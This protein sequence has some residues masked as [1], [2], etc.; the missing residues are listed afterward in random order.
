MGVHCLLAVIV[1]TGVEVMAV[2]VVTAPVGVISV[3]VSWDAAG[4][5]V[6]VTSWVC[7]RSDGVTAGTVL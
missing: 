3:G 5:S 1:G 2:E 7:A 6:S 4:V